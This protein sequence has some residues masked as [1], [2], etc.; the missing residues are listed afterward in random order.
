MTPFWLLLFLG[1]LQGLT[2]FL[3]VSSSAHL[4][5]FQHFFHFKG[6]R[7]FFDVLLHFATLLAVFVYFRKDILKILTS[8]KLTLMVVMASFPTAII[9]FSLKSFVEKLVYAPKVIAV[10][11]LVSAF[12]VWMCDK[13]KGETNLENV[14]YRTSLIA[15]IFQGFAVIPGIS[16]SGSTVFALLLCGLEREEAASF[17]FIISIPA[18]LGATFLELLKAP[19]VFNSSYVLPMLVAFLSGLLA[20]HIFVDFLK[21]K[22]FS[23]FSIYLIFFSLFILIF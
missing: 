10:F 18:I 14:G 13:L 3:P 6:D 15:G 16:R 11:L 1:V 8:R 20:I 23:F 9:G 21:K 22:N 7:I 4:A 12:L 5:I 17:S 19:L 2:E